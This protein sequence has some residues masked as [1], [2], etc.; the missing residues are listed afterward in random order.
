MNKA[1][2]VQANLEENTMTLIFQEPIVVR[3]TSYILMKE[4]E[5]NKLATAPDLLDVA[6]RLSD[7]LDAVPT[8]DMDESLSNLR[9][10]LQG[11]LDKALGNE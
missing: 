1:E 4:E 10:E 5:F 9:D 11:V 6:I 2:L 7:A 3:K 8:E